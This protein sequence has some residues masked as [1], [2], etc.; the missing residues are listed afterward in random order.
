MKAQEVTRLEYGPVYAVGDFT[1]TAADMSETAKNTPQ[2]VSV[3]N[4][5]VTWCVLGIC[6]VGWSI[7]G[8]FLWVP[9]LLAAVLLFSLDLVQSTVAERGAMTAGR[10][11][12]A[13]ATFYGRGF[14]SAVE[15]IR[16]RRGED[17][18]DSDG[19]W[20][21]ESR[22]ILRETAWALVVWYVIMWGA[23]VPLLTP[24]DLLS[25]VASAPW[26]EVW[27]SIV[28]AVPSI[29]IPELIRG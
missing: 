19:D 25:S 15:S 21:I 16:Q 3:L 5:V 26:P 1:E 24:I 14:A 18:E 22:L 17:E 2:P 4:D 13:A 20:S 28:G 27:S 8:L 23:G 7:I 11:L 10:R 9:R 29:P 6:L 12:R